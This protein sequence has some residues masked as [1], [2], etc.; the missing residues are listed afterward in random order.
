MIQCGGDKTAQSIKME[1]KIPVSRRGHTFNNCQIEKKIMKYENIE[2]A[3]RRD[4]ENILRSINA[5]F[6]QKI[7]WN[8]IKKKEIAGKEISTIR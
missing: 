6:I 5:I 8:E 2:K 4:D 1:N 7:I 3:R